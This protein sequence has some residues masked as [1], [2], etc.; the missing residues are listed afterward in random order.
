L[1]GK[2]NYPQGKFSKGYSFWN[3]TKENWNGIDILRSPLV[4][5]GKGGGI[6]LMV[7]YFSFA[8]FASLRA[9]F[10][11]DKFDLIFVYEPSPITVGIPAVLL[12]KK[13]NIPLYFWVQDLWPE[14]LVAAGQI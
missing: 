11:K 5:R 13:L 8:F 7:N 12:S 3:K 6:K 10:I 4:P 14:S 9:L 2:P 1:T